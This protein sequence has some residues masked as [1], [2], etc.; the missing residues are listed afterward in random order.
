VIFAVRGA[1]LKIADEGTIITIIFDCNA[2]RLR[3][4]NFI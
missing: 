4:G 1:G 2:E 3:R